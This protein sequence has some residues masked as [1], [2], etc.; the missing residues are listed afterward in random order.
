MLGKIKAYTGYSGKRVCLLE[1]FVNDWY[2]QKTLGTYTDTA[3][4][5]VCGCVR[6]ALNYIMSQNANLTVFLI[7]D[8]YGRNYNSVDCSSS[9]QRNSKTQY[10]YYEEIA[11]VAE[12]LG[13]PVIKEYAGSQI[14]EN[15]PQYLLDNIHPNALG[16]KQSANFIWSKMKQYMPNAI[17]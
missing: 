11:K 15:T 8:P 4:T 10:E 1:G 7:L 16:A 6:S 3:E 13:I 12:S 14:S 9:A 5:T 2:S 17:S